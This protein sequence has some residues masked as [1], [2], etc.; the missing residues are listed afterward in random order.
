MIQGPNNTIKAPAQA[1][2]GGTIRV[3]VAP[4]AGRDTV[5]KVTVPGVPGGSTYPV[6]ANGT[7]NIPVPNVPGG[8]VIILSIGEGADTKAVVVEIVSSFR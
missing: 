5:V 6:G 4:D 2:Q 1:E 3:A 8:S 7:A